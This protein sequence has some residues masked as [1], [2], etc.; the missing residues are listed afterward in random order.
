[1][2]SISPSCPK[3][4]RSPSFHRKCDDRESSTSVVE[5]L[6]TSTNCAPTAAIKSYFASNSPNEEN[7]IKNI[8]VSVVYDIFIKWLNIP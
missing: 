8:K 3:N 4:S 5:N 1:M 2:K 6:A 7:T